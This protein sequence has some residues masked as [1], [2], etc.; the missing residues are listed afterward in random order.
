MVFAVLIIYFAN[1]KLEETGGKK[2]FVFRQNRSLYIVSLIVASLVSI[3]LYAFLELL[4]FGEAMALKELFTD[5]IQ[6]PIIT[7]ISVFITIA[8]WKVREQLLPR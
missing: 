7:T 3:A 5:L 6:Y 1:H 4:T 2:K 8:L